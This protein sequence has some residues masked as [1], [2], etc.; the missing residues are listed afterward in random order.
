MGWANK[1]EGPGGRSLTGQAIP[2]TTRDPATNPN[3][4]LGSKPH[5]ESEQ[6][7][8]LPQRPAPMRSGGKQTGYQKRSMLHPKEPCPLPPMDSPASPDTRRKGAGGRK[9]WLS[10]VLWG[11]REGV[12]QRLAQSCHHVSQGQGGRQ[13]GVQ[14]SPDFPLIHL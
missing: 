3:K 8:D 2:C 4:A 11:G 13:P 6:K 10:V 12:G 7:P 5:Q 9:P 14:F 1:F